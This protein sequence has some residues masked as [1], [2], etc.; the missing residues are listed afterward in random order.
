M[1][2]YARLLRVDHRSDYKRCL[3]VQKPAAFSA[4]YVLQHP[5]C[6]QI[7]ASAGVIKLL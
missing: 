5:A 7:G 2:D 1:L 3:F 4:L 6:S